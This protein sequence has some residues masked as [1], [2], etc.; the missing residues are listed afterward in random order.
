MCASNIFGD[1]ILVEKPK[2]VLVNDTKSVNR[3]K[4]FYFILDQYVRYFDK[5]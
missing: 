2:G 1:L 3:S 4:V 5:K